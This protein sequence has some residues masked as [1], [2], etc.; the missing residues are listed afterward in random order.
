[1]AFGLLALAV[2]LLPWWVAPLYDPPPRPLGERAAEWLAELREYTTGSPD[3]GASSQPA[4]AATNPWRSP[5]LAVAAL[6]LAFAALVSGAIAFVRREDA[7]VTA[8]SVALGA[9]AIAADSVLT[10]V[11]VLVV[12]VTAVALAAVA[13]RA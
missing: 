6:L 7:R 2:S 10:A 4:P 5:R 12:A 8:C 9:G 11:M 1:M 3:P 13:R